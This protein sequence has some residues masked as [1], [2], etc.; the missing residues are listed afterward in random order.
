MQRYPDS[1]GRRRRVAYMAVLAVLAQAL[2]SA[3]HWPMT[4]QLAVGVSA[5][6]NTVVI[7][8][9]RGFQVVRLGSDSRPLGPADHSDPPLAATICPVCATLGAAG[10]IVAVEQAGWPHTAAWHRVV[11]ADATSRWASGR[12]DNRRSRDPPAAV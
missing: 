11:Y 4:Q 2:V 1:A 3:W 12:P 6:S 7:C 9:A 8:T 5:T 10:M